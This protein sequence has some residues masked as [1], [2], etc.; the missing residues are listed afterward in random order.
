MKLIYFLLCIIFVN[1][2]SA[3]TQIDNANTT[4]IFHYQN[5]TLDTIYQLNLSDNLKMIRLDFDIYEFPKVIDLDFNDSK[6][7]HIYVSSVFTK[8]DRILYYE[9]EREQTVYINNLK[10]NL[11]SSTFKTNSSTFITKNILL[12]DI[13]GSNVIYSSKIVIS[14]NLNSISIISDASGTPD[15]Y[16]K[17]LN[18]FFIN[19]FELPYNQKNNSL[20]EFTE[21]NVQY[22]D[23]GISK[24]EAELSKN[25]KS[26]S[27]PFQFVFLI[28]KAILKVSNVLNI[29]SDID[30]YEF[31]NWF[32]TPLQM[33]DTLIKTIIFII[34]FIFKNGILWFI[35]ISLMIIFI[36]SYVRSKNIL[37]TF[38]KFIL[39]SKIYITYVIIK[40]CIWIYEKILIKILRGS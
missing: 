9:I 28:G 22:L 17:I 12:K 21:I 4:E 40:P 29:I 11:Y 8:V 2:V 27:V 34:N 26:L 23:N 36:F 32:L 38:E 35:S 10:V 13:F 16:V 3:L 6:K 19:R 15:K 1:N 39:Y 24:L 5:N 18:P 31:Q 30:Y 7:N 25:F 20:F 37:E 14:F 33:L